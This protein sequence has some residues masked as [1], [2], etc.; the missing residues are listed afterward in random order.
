MPGDRSEHTEELVLNVDK[1]LGIP[2][3]FAVRVL[4]T[5]LIQDTAAPII[6]A[7]HDLS[8]HSAHVTASLGGQGCHRM[9][10]VFAAGILGPLHGNDIFL[11]TG[12]AL[13]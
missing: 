2:D 5:M 12:A 9:L 10:D 1:V 4:N 3:G 7:S 13:H 11:L 6:T 8:A